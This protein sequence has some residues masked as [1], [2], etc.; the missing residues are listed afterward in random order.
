[1]AVDNGQVI[2]DG[3][4]QIAS[5]GLGFNAGTL[6]GTVEYLESWINQTDS[7]TFQYVRTAYEELLKRKL[8][9]DQFVAHFCASGAEA[10]ETTLANFYD[11]RSQ[12]SARCVLA[13]EGSFHG[14]MMVALASTWN[15]AKREPFAWPGYESQFVPYPEMDSDAIHQPVTPESWRSIWS[16]IKEDEFQSAVAAC[17]R[18]HDGLLKKEIDSLT[19]TRQHLASGKI[20]AILI[21]PMQCEG[22]DRY[23]S[24]RFHQALAYLSEVFSV[25]LIYDEIQ[26]GF[27]LGGEFF[28]HRLFDLKQVDGQPFH[29]NGVICAKKAQTGISLV[30]PNANQSADELKQPIREVEQIS[31]ASLIRGYIQA[32]VV[33][34]FRAVIDGMERA[35]RDH[36]N[37][38]ISR[39]P[40]RIHR[41]RSKGVSFAF[42]LETPE[43]INR[44]VANRFQ[45]GLL[46]YPAGAKTARFRLNLGYRD[47]EV[48]LLWAQLE[49]A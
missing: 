32:S 36:L 2:C 49:S 18:N 28:W 12:P 6:F 7:A 35:N 4:S 30:R 27:G 40:N 26:T 37:R 11:L 39:F 25:P 3:A 38:L 15:P 48:D 16:E 47:H 46:Y 44:L 33:D 45:H 8:G 34:Q 9:S 42:D 14:R 19:A 22:G 24:V 41:A 1:M 5:L 31:A 21:E 17:N 20:L 29:P 10:V 23:S 43:L 13:F